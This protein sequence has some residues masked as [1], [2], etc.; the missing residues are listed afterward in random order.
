MKKV[1]IQGIRETEKQGLSNP[2]NFNKIYML[3]GVKLSREWN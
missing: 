3:S 2:G 1:G